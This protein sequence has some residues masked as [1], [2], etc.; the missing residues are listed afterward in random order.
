MANVTWTVDGKDLTPDLESAKYDVTGDKLVNGEDVQAILDYVLGKRE[1]IGEHADL[2]GDEEVTSYDAYLLL[3]KLGT[4]TV[5]LPAGGKLEVAVKFQL[6]EDQKARLDESYRNGA[7][8]QGFV[9]AQQL[10]T[11]EGV[12]GTAHSIPVLGFYGNWTDATMFDRG[13]FISKLYGDT[14]I[15]YA[16]YMD[17][18]LKIKYAGSP[19]EYY[20]C[21]LY[22]SDAADE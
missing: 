13:T 22:T 19:A 7:Y 10:T 9:F 20:Y 15:P 12:E 18:S 16:A 17:S 2:N 6:T 4:G 1:T 21:L 14:T 8:V 5:T 3:Q 11:A